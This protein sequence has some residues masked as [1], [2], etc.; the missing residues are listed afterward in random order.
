MREKEREREERESMHNYTS[1]YFV[2]IDIPPFLTTAKAARDIDG[3]LI[4][5]VLPV[6]IDIGRARSFI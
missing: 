4:F 5:Y 2:F 6:N 1:N 3:V